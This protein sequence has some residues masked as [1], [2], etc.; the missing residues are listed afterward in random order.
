[1]IVYKV[2]PLTS[3]QRLQYDKSTLKIRKRYGSYDAV[4]HGIFEATKVRTTGGTVRYWFVNQSI[5]VEFA[6]VFD[7]LFPD[8][9][10]LSDFYPWLVSYLND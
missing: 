1:M 3:K 10:F 2:F 9:S 6:V 4:A 5:P 7:T 8:E